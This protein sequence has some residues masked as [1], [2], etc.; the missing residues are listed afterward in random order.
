MPAAA[1]RFLRR[2]E[3]GYPDNAYH[4]AIH[5]ADVVQTLSLLLRKGG[6]LPHYACPVTHLAAL[7]AAV[8]ALRCARSPRAHAQ[9]VAP[10][11]RSQAAIARLQALLLCAGVQAAHDFGHLGRTN[12]F[13]VTT[14]HEL[15]LVYNDRAPLENHHI[16]SALG[17]LRCPE[18]NFLASLSKV[19]RRACVPFPL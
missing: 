17:L 5:A 12:D 8:S 19:R 18:Y 1:R 13:L 3:S 15:A 11:H 4:S 6:L 16:S 7:L 2:V 14:G 10:R 9:H